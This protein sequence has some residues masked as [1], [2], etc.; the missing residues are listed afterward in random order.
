MKIVT[1]QVV[2]A[3]AFMGFVV[4]GIERDWSIWWQIGGAFCCIGV[5]SRPL[6]S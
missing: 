3:I 1:A 2:L 4:A 5:L 6:S